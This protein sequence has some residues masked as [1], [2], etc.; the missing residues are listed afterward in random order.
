MLSKKFY[1]DCTGYGGGSMS[2]LA[3]LLVTNKFIGSDSGAFLV[4]NL[5]AGLSLMIYTY[6]KEAYA[7][8]LL[9]SF[10]FLISFLAIARIIY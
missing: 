5:V 8:T 6:S 2:L 9:N 4:L 10:W 7:N 3:Y 1:I